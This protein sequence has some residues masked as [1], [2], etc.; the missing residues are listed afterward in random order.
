MLGYQR[1]VYN[2]GDESLCIIYSAFFFLFVKTLRFS[3]FELLISFL[4]VLCFTRLCCSGQP[5]KDF[6]TGALFHILLSAVVSRCPKIQSTVCSQYLPAGNCRPYS[7]PDLQPMST[8]PSI[9]HPAP[10]ILE[11]T[12]CRCGK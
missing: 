3:E 6:P 2:T 4:C 9:S 8:I 11:G 10:W 12:S 7:T 1:A 5:K